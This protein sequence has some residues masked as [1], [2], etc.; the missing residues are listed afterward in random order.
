VRDDEFEQELR[1][2]RAAD[3]RREGRQRV[4]LD[5][6]DQRTLAE[7]PVDDH[8]DAA[9]ARQRQDARLHLAVEHVVCHLH[10]IDRLLRHDAFDVAKRIRLAEL[11]QAVAD[12]VLRRA[13]HGRRIDHAAAGSEEGAHHIGASIPR[14]L[15]VA[16][17]ER[18]PRPKTD[19]RDGLTAGRDLSGDGRG[20]LGQSDRRQ[21]KGSGRG[22]EPGEHGAAVKT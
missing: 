1:P 16:D 4:T 20:G 3:L 10:K 21:A 14:D 13:V 22:G 6:P 8:A 5:L 11:A 2:V 19:H 17:I 7:R 18:D 9:L 15:V 12:H